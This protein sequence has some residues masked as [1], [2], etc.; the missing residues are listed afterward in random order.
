MMIAQ[1]AALVFALLSAAFW[2][3]PVVLFPPK[4]IKLNVYKTGETVEVRSLDLQ[5]LAHYVTASSRLNSI[6]ASFSGLAV[7]AQAVALWLQQHQ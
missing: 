2:W 4:D 7:F 1:L 3:L 6:A 5:I